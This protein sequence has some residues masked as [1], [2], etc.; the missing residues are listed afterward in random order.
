M[1]SKYWLDSAG[2]LQSKQI[3]AI[4]DACLRTDQRFASVSL[5]ASTSEAATVIALSRIWC[6]IQRC[7]QVGAEESP[8]D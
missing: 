8:V 5:C 1:K 6:S 2:R 7:A 4:L 3:T